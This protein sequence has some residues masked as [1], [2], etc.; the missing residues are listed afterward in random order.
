MQVYDDRLQAE[1]HPD[2]AWNRS[3]KTCMKLNQYRMYSRKFLMMDREDARN[4]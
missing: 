3:S 2:S 1:F 4:M